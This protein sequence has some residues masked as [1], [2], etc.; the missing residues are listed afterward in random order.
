MPCHPFQTKGGTS[1]FICTGKAVASRCEYT[2]GAFKCKRK[3]VA[4][5]DYPTGN[6]KT[7]DM[8]LCYVHRIP[9]GKKGTDFCPKHDLMEIPK[10]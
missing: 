4:L 7:C 6:G 2:E 1:G 8:K 10:K 3:H 9:H 5:C